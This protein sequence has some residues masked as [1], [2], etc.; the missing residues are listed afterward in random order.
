[1]ARQKGIIKLTGKIGDLSF[2]KTQDGFLAREKGGVEADRIKNDPAFVRTRENGAEFGSSAQSGK[3]L[4]DS[5]RTMMQ[6]ASDG[7]VTSRLTKLMTQV[8]NLDGVSARG[9]RNVGVGVATVEAKALLKGFNFNN[10]AIL[11][12]ILFNGYSVVLGTGEIT[13]A[14]LVPINELNTPSGATHISLRGAW[15]K[16]DFAT[17]EAEMQE[18]NVVNLPIDAN[19][20]N[21]VLTPVAAPQGGGTDLYFLMIE[22]FQQVNGNQYTLKNGAFNALSIVE[23]Q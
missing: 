5:V 13:L 15:A 14:D 19:S 22:F 9:E 11:G 20:S 1:M 18:T 21:V 10:K 3:L 6:N 2:Y 4:R 23:V 8:K 17:G 12:S 7:R 16:V